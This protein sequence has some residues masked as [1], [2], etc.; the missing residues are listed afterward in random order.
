MY[1]ASERPDDCLVVPLPF[2][3]VLYGVCRVVTARCY[4]AMR[5]ELLL[6]PEL[7]LPRAAPMP[8]LSRRPVF[9]FPP[10]L[11]CLP[12]PQRALNAAARANIQ[13]ATVTETPL[14]D[15]GLDGSGE[16]V[17]VG[18]RFILAEDRVVGGFHAV[19]VFAA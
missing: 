11:V 18:A 17:Q 3:L 16:V 5:V 14:T 6:R 7:G 9:F 1:T 2:E 15:A 13:S 19:V 4:C 10:S 8:P 12:P